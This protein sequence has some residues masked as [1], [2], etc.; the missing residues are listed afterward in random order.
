MAVIPVSFLQGLAG[1]LVLIGLFFLWVTGEARLAALALLPNAFPIVVMFGGG[2]LLGI[3]LNENLVL[4]MSVA[5]GVSV[6]DTLHFLYHYRHATLAGRPPREAVRE[7][8]VTAGSPIVVTSALLLAGF[9]VCLTSSI[10]AMREMG[11]LLGLAISSALLADLLLLPALLLRF[12]R[13]DPAGE[14]RGYGVE[15]GGV[16]RARR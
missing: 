13:P 3:P 6:D 11:I 15:R 16:R 2:R 12:D 8:V 5:I 7:A 10:T 14:A 1:C 9:S 4:S